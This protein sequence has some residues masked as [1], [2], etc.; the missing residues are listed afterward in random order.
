MFKER[1][2]WKRLFNDHR[3]M[4][5]L[6]VRKEA[7]ST[8]PEHVS[9]SPEIAFYL[10]ADQKTYEEKLEKI[11]T[12]NR[13]T[14]NFKRMAVDGVLSSVSG[15]HVASFLM[16]IPRG[17]KIMLE[18]IKGVEKAREGH[19]LIVEKIFNVYQ[20]TEI[21]PGNYALKRGKWGEEVHIV[22]AVAGA[23]KRVPKVIETGL[24]PKLDL[25][26]LQKMVEAN[27]SRD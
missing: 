24:D 16:G 18:D 10:A 12:D 8:L 27:K 19:D 2:V 11:F 1:S 17:W 13:A 22:S 7:F 20:L 4:A 14:E 26:R 6:M 5:D 9:I 3:M 25:Q 15:I 23:T 21:A